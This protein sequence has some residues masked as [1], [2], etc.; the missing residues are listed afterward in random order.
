MP[1]RHRRDARRDNKRA[2]ELL[3]APTKLVKQCA[4]QQTHCRA[5][6]SSA[7]AMV[8]WY[9]GDAHAAATGVSRADDTSTASL[10]MWHKI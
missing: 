6:N 7:I 5:A 9:E 10:K 1:L 3:A 4:W 2:L 8:Q